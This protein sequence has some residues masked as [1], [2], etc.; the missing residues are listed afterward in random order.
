MYRHIGVPVH[1][2]HKDKLGKALRTAT[3]LAAHYDSRLT[4]VGVTGPAPSDI[5]RSPAEFGEKLERYALELGRDAG[6]DIGT[7]VSVCN[8]PATELRK[9]L[10]REFHDLRVDLVIMASHVPGF[11][12]YIF[13]SNAGYLAS[14]TDLSVFVVRGYDPD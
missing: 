8:D 10:D 12:D 2:A 6:V 5:A 7:R 3:D 13:S 11:R 4:L 9:A 1:L 14:H